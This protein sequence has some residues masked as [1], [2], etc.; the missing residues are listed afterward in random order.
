MLQTQ[1]STPNPDDGIKAFRPEKDCALASHVNAEPARALPGTV[2]FNLDRLTAMWLGALRDHSHLANVLTHISRNSWGDVERALRSIFDGNVTSQDLSPL[3]RNIVDLLCAD[4]GVT[5][6]IMKPY[7][8]V[9]LASALPPD[10]ARRLSAHVTKLFLELEAPNPFGRDS[11]NVKTIAIIQGSSTASAQELFQDIVERWS[12]QIRIAGVIEERDRA[13]RRLCRAGSLRSLGDNSL[14]PMFEDTASSSA[15]C[16]VEQAGLGSAAVAIRRDVE[17]GCDLVILSKFGKLE[18]EGLGLRAAFTAC[19][20]AKIPLLTYVPIRLSRP[21]K[22]L[23]GAQ[24]IFLPAEALAIDD[25][26]RSLSN[27]RHAMIAFYLAARVGR[28]VAPEPGG[29]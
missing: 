3:A 13:N 16:D 4:R 28:G 25:W 26:L 8:R 15:G 19:V 29:K 11:E 6:R 23:V 7:F 27:I 20:E 10:Q 2:G 5:G 22:S 24:S 1:A 9:F 12:P 21:W 14:Y 18:A 17:T